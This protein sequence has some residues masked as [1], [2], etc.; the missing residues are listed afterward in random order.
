M[1]AECRYDERS[2]TMTLEISSDTASERALLRAFRV[3]GVAPKLA[4]RDVNNQYY[5]DRIEMEL[6]IGK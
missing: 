2:Q 5:Y 4:E 3:S 6:K 1:K